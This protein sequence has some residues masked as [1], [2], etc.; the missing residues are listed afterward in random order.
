[1]IKHLTKLILVAIESKWALSISTLT[2]SSRK[3]LR[4][5][6]IQKNFRKLIFKFLTAIKINSFQLKSINTLKDAPMRV[7]L[8][9]SSV[10]NQ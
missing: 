9:W 5:V 1:M 6:S 4:F 7:H 10:G 8:S 2:N 3:N